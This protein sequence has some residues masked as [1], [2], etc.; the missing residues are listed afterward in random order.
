MIPV[1]SVD[2]RSRGILV[3]DRLALYYETSGNSGNYWYGSF[4]ALRYF[5][6]SDLNDMAHAGA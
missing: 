3:S 2:K 1:W 4:D 6:I 5:R